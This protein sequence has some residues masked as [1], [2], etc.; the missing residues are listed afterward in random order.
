M[1]RFRSPS[2]LK[3]AGAILVALAF[4]AVAVAVQRATHPAAGSQLLILLAVPDGPGAETLEIR[5]R[6]ARQL[7]DAFSTLPEVRILQV[8]QRSAD[9]EAVSEARELGRR[10]LAAIVVGEA[11]MPGT[12]APSVFVEEVS[13]WAAVPFLSVKDYVTEAVLVE[14]D[15]L[16]FPNPTAEQGQRV[17]EFIRATVLHHRGDYAG[18]LEHLTAAVDENSSSDVMSKVLMSRGNVLLALGRVETAIEDYSRAI[19]INPSLQGVYANRGA[20]F[21]K[22]ASHER[23]A[24]DFTRAEQFGQFTQVNQAAGDAAQ[25][26]YQAAIDAYDRLIRANPEDGPAYLNRGVSRAALGEHRRAVDDFS[27]ALQLSPMDATA[28][29]DR[30]LSYAAQDMLQRAI[31]DYSAALRLAPRSAAVHYARGVAQAG[32]GKYEQ[33]VEDLTRAIQI[34]PAFGAAYRDR[35]ASHLLLGRL[36]RA[37]ADATTALGLDPHDANAFFNRG[38]SFILR[39]DAQK[40]KADMQK[41]LKL[42]NEPA[43]RKKAQEQLDQLRKEE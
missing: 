10:Y 18:A 6:L 9:P 23:A 26:R 34:D 19:Q 32:L 17:V 21:L 1:S 4:S 31:D 29:F 40:A 11:V 20:A 8:N 36:D 39:G 15:S 28:Y 30:G 13:P 43:L 35:G 5:T 38:L 12:A 16:R 42:S 22:L 33:S 2:R 14:P 41:V 37:I 27:R 3:A 25:G 7:A 24:G